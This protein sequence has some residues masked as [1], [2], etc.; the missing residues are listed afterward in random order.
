MVSIIT[1]KSTQS[2]RYLIDTSNFAIHI[3]HDDM[4][5]FSY[6]DW[7]IE[8]VRASIQNETVSDICGR[9]RVK[10][11]TGQVGMFSL[12]T[13]DLACAMAFKTL[14]KCLLTLYPTCEC[15]YKSSTQFKKTPH[16]SYLPYVHPLVLGDVSCSGVL[17]WNVP[18]YVPLLQ[19]LVADFEYSAA[20][21][22]FVGNASR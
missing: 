1:F 20:S 15:E 10:E 21:R 17:L 8:K 18:L 22:L 16:I 9:R 19:Y 13:P 14:S 4:L 7:Y 11:T 5:I 3:H 6:K 12:S 2:P